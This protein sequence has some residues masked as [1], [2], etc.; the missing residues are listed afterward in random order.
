MTQENFDLSTEEGII[1]KCQNFLTRSSAR[2]CDDIEKQVRALVVAG[3]NFWNDEMKK[4]WSILDEHGKDIIPT[5]AYNNISPQV[6]AIASPFC[7]SPFHVNIIDKTEKKNKELQEKISHVEGS[8]NSKMVFQKAMTR[9]VTCSA[10]YVVIGTEFDK[11]GTLMPNIEFVSNQKMVA[12][13][14]DC[15]TPDCSDAEEGALI[16][17]INVNKAKRDYGEDVV[18]QDFPNTQPALSFNNIS[19][20]VTRENQIQLVRY[21]CKDR[22][23]VRDEFGNVM[24]DEI[25][26]QPLKGDRTIVNMYTICGNK[27]IGDVV[28]MDTD[29]IPIVRFAGYNDYDE[30]YGQVYTGYVQKMGSYIEQMSLALTMQATRMRRCSN[31]RIVAGSSAVEGCEGYFVDFEKGSSIGLIYN[32]KAGANAPTIVNDTFPT[33][34]ISAVLQEGR[35]TMQECSGINLAGINT[36]ERTAY[37]VMQQQVNSESNVQEIYLNAEAACHTIG[38]IMLGIMN[39]GIIP[40]FTLEGGP[41]VITA[42]MKERAEI[43]AVSSMVSAEHQELLAMRM[44][45]TIT[46]DVGKAIEQDIKANC[47]LN[48]AGDQDIGTVINA[49]EKMKAQ[50]DETMKELQQAKSEVEELQKA[51]Y[52]LEMQLADNRASR[53]LDERKFQAQMA[54]DEAQL[55]IEN[56][57]AAKKLAQEDD[58]IALK[59]RKDDNDDRM[60]RSRIALEAMKNRFNGGY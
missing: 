40:D 28:E 38:K 45:S 58:R 49:C 33:N 29:I 53:E 44:A 23:I 24:Y 41:S 55:S 36:T 17:Y 48:L 51:N 22:N 21:F 37:E 57:E 14:P 59:A 3:G 46:S 11:K 26:G 2:F 10:G 5:I 13:D 52:S 1:K 35:Q 56:A 12:V 7:R 50:L 9:G 32:D 20:W 18:P 39:N 43:Q 47:G 27:V 30:E 16:S 60:N 31:V 42:Q 4:R 8:N 15:I 25:T 54:K 34:D 6:N 19:C